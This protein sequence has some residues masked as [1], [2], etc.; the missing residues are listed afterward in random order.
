M[1]ARARLLSVGTLVLTL[2][3]GSLPFLGES[4]LVGLVSADVSDPVPWPQGTAPSESFLSAQL[5]DA[6]ALYARERRDEFL[7]AAERGEDREHILVFQEDIDGG[8][9]DLGQL[10]RFGDALFEHEFRA[11]DGLGTASKQ[12]LA[13]VHDGRRGGLDTFS[14]AGCHS[15]GGFDGA[16]AA[17]QNAYVGGDGDALSSANV[18][19]PPHTLG[20]GMVQRLA[21][22]MSYDLGQQ[23]EAA[24]AAATSE[25][26]DVSVALE[27][28][29]VSFGTLVADNGGGVDYSM[30]EGVDPDL[31]VKPFGWKGEV[32]TLRRFVEEAARIHF[33]VQAH[34]LA[35]AHKDAPDPAALGNGPWFDP[36]NDGV[37]RELEEGS[38]TAGAI[39]LAM[40]EVPV[41]LPPFDPTLRERWA[42]GS[43]LFDDAGCNSCHTRTLQ[44]S[45]PVWDEYPDTTGGPPVKLELL[46][47]G[48][49]PRGSHVVELFSDLKRHDMGDELADTYA[50]PSGL[51]RSVF[52]TRP[53]WGLA[54]TGPFL[55]DGRALTLDEAI[56]AH[57]GEGAT[58]RDLY[59][60][61]EPAAQ[62]DLTVFLLSLTRSPRLRVPR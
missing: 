42:R 22:E 33:G 2:A 23:R 59:L 41:V 44:M 16:G 19:S 38:I 3:A 55:H 11:S 31:V 25:G 53:L 13:R 60:A 52:L 36:D 14:C 4:N 15:Q 26:V 35:L 9:Y 56:R 21:A 10:F 28:K 48:D 49:A 6:D 40:L 7:E 1:T 45:L 61:L 27:S 12:G 50:S 47:D 39:Y 34:T 58:S 43:V 8:A 37:Q 29:G 5:E 30:I 18:R 54:E 57:G 32:A 46:V 20:L 62:R 24:I 51:A 17:T